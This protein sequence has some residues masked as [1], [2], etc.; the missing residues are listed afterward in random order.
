MEIRSVLNDIFTGRSSC[1][2]T[3]AGPQCKVP[4]LD[5]NIKYAVFQGHL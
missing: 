4:D 1:T 2:P 5:I 3:M